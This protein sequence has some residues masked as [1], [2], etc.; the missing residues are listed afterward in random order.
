MKTVIITGAAGNLGSAVVKTFL[1][2]NYKV[3]ACLSPRDNPGSKHP[4]V[5]VFPLDLTNGESCK[6]F[7]DNVINKY[8]TIDAA[9]LTVGGFAT[10]DIE[11]VTKADFDKM[12]TLNFITAFNIAQP[13]V[14]QMKTQTTGG[15]II[16]IA[17]EPGRDGGKAKGSVA[18]GFSKS[19]LFRLAQLL[20]KKF[21]FLFLLR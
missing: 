7:S 13:M 18:Y 9:V 15:K 11:S 6:I 4:D 20:A 3:I 16:L 8:K 14:K 21:L 1:Q 17:A 12:F 2:K 19:L 10:G 5:E